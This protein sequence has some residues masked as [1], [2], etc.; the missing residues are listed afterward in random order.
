MLFSKI[1]KALASVLTVL[2]AF[3]APVISAEP[4]NFCNDSA[5]WAPY[6]YHP[7]VNGTPDTKQVI[8]FTKNKRKAPGFIRGD[9]SFP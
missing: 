6:Y 7:R 9:I 2:F 3:S 1:N 5:E 4:I 8:G